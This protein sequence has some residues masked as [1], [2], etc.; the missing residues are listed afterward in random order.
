VYVIAELLKKLFRESLDPLI[1]SDL[2]S[3]I[4]A[5]VTQNDQ[6]SVSKSVKSLVGLMSDIHRRIL[7][8]MTYF[9]A[10]VVAHEEL[11][12]SAKRIASIFANCVFHSDDPDTL[13][14]ISVLL[15]ILIQERRT[16][17]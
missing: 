7:K 17:F 10:T 5:S 13:Q 15:T 12:I 14:S 16:M 6:A 3:M 9:W 11:A 4:S 2:A 8:Y 1:P